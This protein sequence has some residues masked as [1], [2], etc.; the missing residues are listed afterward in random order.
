MGQLSEGPDSS[1]DLQ[2]VLVDDHLALRKGIELLLR[3]EG[4]R[5]IGTA[6]S[7]VRA[8]DIVLAGRPDVTVLDI[9][10]ERG[11]GVDV[12]REVLAEWPDAG[13]LMYTGGTVDQ[14]VLRDA[15]NCGARGFA[16]K[17][18]PSSELVAAIRTVAG[19]GDYVD[20]RLAALLDDRELDIVQLL[21]P[22]E[23]EVLELLAAGLT[24]EEIAER[25]VL[26]PMTV[27]THVRNLMRRLGARTRVHAL[28]LA[29]RSREI[30]ITT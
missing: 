17:A 11:N 28:A 27:Q 9:A 2:V 25:L 15:L 18:G 16:L 4:F 14:E 19:G 26:S 23:R 3:A 21:S 6:E 1:D 12:A 22:R 29:L 5:I 13:I 8:R 20:P 30:E 10:L 7:S 24:G